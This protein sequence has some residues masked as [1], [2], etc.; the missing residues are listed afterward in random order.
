[1]LLVWGLYSLL[2]YLLGLLLVAVLQYAKGPVAPA[3]DAVLLV[4]AHPDDESMFFVPTILLQSNI[5]ILCLSNGD[6]DGLG[7]VRESEL[8]RAS[9]HFGI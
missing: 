9:E 1:M 6:Y 3:A 5:S 7:I 4:I 2:A 8:Q